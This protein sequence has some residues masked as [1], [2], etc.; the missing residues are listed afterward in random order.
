MTIELSALICG[1]P[2]SDAHNTVLQYRNNIFQN[3]DRLLDNEL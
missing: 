1:Q 3:E 2:V